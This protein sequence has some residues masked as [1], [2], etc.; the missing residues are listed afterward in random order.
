MPRLSPLEATCSTLAFRRG[1]PTFFPYQWC[2][3]G[4][5][6]GFD[7]APSPGFP[8]SAGSSPLAYS[9]TSGQVDEME[10]SVMP[11]VSQPPAPTVQRFS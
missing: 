11:D 1:D 5:L 4:R 9:P 8:T 7:Q 2:E 6:S 3:R 10:S